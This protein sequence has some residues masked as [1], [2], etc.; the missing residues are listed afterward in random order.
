M[1]EIWSRSVVGPGLRA[2]RTWMVESPA[3]H[4]LEGGVYS[5]GLGDSSSR[6]LWGQ[7]RALPKVM[8]GAL[9]LKALKA[10]FSSVLFTMIFSE[11]TTVAGTG[12]VVG[13]TN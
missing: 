13:I 5:Q 2:G 9:R 1:L 3:H 12:Q 11:P 6:E 4:P 10:G 7:T 8:L